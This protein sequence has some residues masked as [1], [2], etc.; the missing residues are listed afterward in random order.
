[1][2]GVP[3]QAPIGPALPISWVSLSS[4]QAAIADYSDG[5]AVNI[6][7]SEVKAG[8]TPAA[9]YF[10]WADSSIRNTEEP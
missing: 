9:T 4:A 7:G 2:K 5:L 10:T 8:M 6:D 1:M 3:F